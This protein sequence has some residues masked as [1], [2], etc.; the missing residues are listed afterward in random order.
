MGAAKVAL[1]INDCGHQIIEK[2]PVGEVAI[3]TFDQCYFVQ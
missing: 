2:G 3:H 1:D